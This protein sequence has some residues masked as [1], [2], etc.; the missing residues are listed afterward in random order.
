MKE[1]VQEEIAQINL[2]T[3]HVDFDD[4]PE[5]QSAMGVMGASGDTKHLWDPMKPKEVEE[6]RKL[7]NLLTGHGYRAFRLRKDGRRRAGDPDGHFIKEFEPH[8]H[9]ILFL[10]PMSGG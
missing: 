2:Q 8:L 6:A 10:A 3:T 1:Q 9:G 5:G 7:F 4:L